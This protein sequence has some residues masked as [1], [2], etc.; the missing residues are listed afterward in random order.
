M[1]YDKID[2]KINVNVGEDQI[3]VLSDYV[4][5]L[6]PTV[7]K[8][9]LEKIS[10]IGVDPSTISS[11]QCT[12]ECLPPIESMDLVSY[13]VLTTSCYTKDQ[14]KA[15]KSLEAYNQM[16]SGFVTGVQGCIV[17]DKFVVLAKVRHSQRMNDPLVDVWIIA[18]KDGAILSS[19]CLGCKAGLCEVCSHVACV[20]FYIEAFMRIH[21]KLACTQVK[22][23]WLLP[24]F[25][26]EVSYERV[27]N[28]NF[29]S[30]QKLK[31]ELDDKIEKLGDDYDSITVNDEVT[32]NDSMQPT[33]KSS[34]PTETEL[35][36][37]YTELNKC[38]AKPVILSLIKPFSSGF[39]SDSAKIETI[40][41]LFDK[42]YLDY[43][44]PD[45]LTAC[46]NV[47]LNLT[48]QEIDQIE[49]DTRQQAKC[50]SF[51]RHRAGRIGASQSGAAS[52]TN[53]YSPSQSLIKSTC[54]PD[55]FK[56]SNDAVIHGCKYEK[57]ALLHYE[58]EMKKHHKD[59]KITQCGLVV[60]KEHQFIHATPDFLCSCS[61]CG[62]GCGEIKCPISIKDNNFDDYILKKSSCLQKVDG[63]FKLKRDHNYYNQ[64]QQQLFTVNRGYC[65][66]IVYSVDD[67]KQGAFIQERIV[68]D[69]KH[70]ETNL[71][72]LTKFWYT[73]ILPEVLGR[74]YTKR[75]LPK[76][77]DTS[78][79]RNICFCRM[80]KAD[81][82]VTCSNTDCPY[83]EFHLSCLSIS[84]K[85]DM[86]AKWLCPHCQ[87]L[88]KFKRA[89]MVSSAL[90]QVENKAVS[91]IHMCLQ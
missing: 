14:F 39:V 19:H 78:G 13:L 90:S 32:N 72:I 28:I 91:T 6:E 83:T 52:K 54:Y 60:N 5:A 47:R 85:D 15:F 76:V 16:V 24:T 82:I 34:G 86:P 65:D 62:E 27:E 1:N 80:D 3:P 41:Q 71:P 26:K 89:K 69:K 33:T 21:G 12:S 77:N 66:F 43:D 20:L 10:I 73:C 67:Q 48:E 74:W 58:N 88:Q 63:V 25:V 7:K 57:E 35:N 38:E 18:E 42:K 29:S 22:C 87:R 68:Q 55:L 79:P 45:L 84:S 37:F 64:V 75:S 31:R 53:P 11:E 81:T 2:D 49:K 44:Y 61:C 56:I 51:F 17:A 36:E 8:R 30:A 46:K 50:R 70:W 59:F 9:Y 4:K 23:T 40:I